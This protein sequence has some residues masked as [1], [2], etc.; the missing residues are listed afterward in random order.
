MIIERLERGLLIS[1]ILFVSFYIVLLILEPIVEP[2]KPELAKGSF[3]S[4]VKSTTYET[5]K[6][7]KTLDKFNNMGNNKI[8]SYEGT[9]PIYIYTSDTLSEKGRLG[10]ALVGRHECEITIQTNLE[11]R[12]FEAVLIHEYLHCMGFIEHSWVWGD[13]MFYKQSPKRTENVQRYA[14]KLQGMLNDL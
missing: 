12:L 2:T 1:L 6:I 3:I 7:Q 13:L 11:G 8:V 10:Q 4:E 9:R 14:N 5:K